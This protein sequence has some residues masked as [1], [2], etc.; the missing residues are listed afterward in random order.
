MV[1]RQSPTRRPTINDVATAAGVSR[2]T[3]SRVL[4]GGRWVSPDATHAVEAAI[5]KT[6]YRVNPHARSLATARTG[7]V[8]FL[9]NETTDRLFS[10]PNF[11]VL[12]TAASQA[13]AKRDLTLVLIL[14]GSDE[15][16]RRARDFLLG[17]H[18]DGVLVVSWHRNSD[19]SL[20]LDLTRANIPVIACGIPLEL[21]NKIAWVAADDYEGAR[22]MTRHLID[23][24]RHH[25]ATITG[26]EDQPGGIQRLRAF[27]DE[28]GDA[29]DPA[30]VA[31]GDYSFASGREGMATLFD[32]GRPIDGVFAA[33]DAMAAGAIAEIQGRGLRVPHDIAV[34]GFDDS[35]IARS[36]SP[37]ITT[38]HQPFDQITSE[39]VRL[40]VGA[41]DGERRSTVLIHTDLIERESTGTP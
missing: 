40:L 39:M 36:C 5:R 24:G 2:G 21:E 20:L 25:L 12:L 26:P 31:S 17:G 19:R 15:E 41:I 3:V 7:S 27:R 30:L 22:E 37:S 18:V 6:G 1:D 23:R 9:L 13:V 4:N 14:A 16:R 35:P 11:S 33:N 38:M 29:F 8:A 10:D 34:G 32:A 28:L